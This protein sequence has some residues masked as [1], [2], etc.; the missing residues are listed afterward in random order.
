MEGIWPPAV[1]RNIL[2]KMFCWDHDCHTPAESLNF[3]VFRDKEGKIES[4]RYSNDNQE[5][6]TA[7]TEAEILMGFWVDAEYDVA[8]FICE[9]MGK[10]W[11]ADDEHYIKRCKEK[12]L[13]VPEMNG[14]YDHMKIDLWYNN[15]N[16]ETSFDAL[17]WVIKDGRVYKPEH[18]D[19]EAY[20]KVTKESGSDLEWSKKEVLESV[21]TEHPAVQVAWQ[22]D[23]AASLKTG[24]PIFFG[25]HE[26]GVG[27]NGWCP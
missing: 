15:S 23:F 6:G 8:K 21:K 20:Q 17:K 9:W 4:I 14:G 26:N 25:P 22:G 1:P 12:G 18:I 27:S 11:D 2:Y 7:Y 10:Q 13:M 16:Y 19:W 5:M 24:S 3:C